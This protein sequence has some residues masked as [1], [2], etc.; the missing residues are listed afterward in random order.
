MRLT[1]YI[2]DLG[3][4]VA[5]YPSLKRVTGSTTASILLCQLLYWTDKTED[6][7]IYKT[8]Y[9]LEDETGLTYYEQKNARKKLRELG[10]LREQFKRLDHTNRYK[11][12]Q[13]VLNDLWEEAHGR[14]K[15]VSEPQTEEKPTEEKPV[16]LLDYKDPALI[17]P[18]KKKEP[19]MPRTGVKKDGDFLD[20]IVEHANSPAG[21]KETA[22]N[23]IREDIERELHINI[24]G[25][26]WDKFV[27]YAYNRQEKY[28]EPVEKFI[29]WAKKEKR[30]GFKTV[31]WTPEKLIMLYPQAFE[32]DAEE[33]EFIKELPPRKEDDSIPMPDYVKVK[34][35][36]T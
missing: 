21:L 17:I 27:D 23:K 22:K 1:N 24:N 19:T 10:I 15:P 12:N 16:S 32:K 18:F 35:K 36:L 7:W 29:I 8:H 31:F 4:V 30:E 14:G 33:V 34:R 28:N 2:K 20:A 6:G 25:L 9:D 26:K 13:K 3:K 5:F 11:I